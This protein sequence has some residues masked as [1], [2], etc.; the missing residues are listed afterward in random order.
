V[1]SERFSPFVVL[2]WHICLT[3]VGHN[4]NAFSTVSSA[5]GRSRYVVPFCIIPAFGQVSENS[6][7]PPASFFT[8]AS[9]QVCDVL[10]DDVSRSKF[11]N[12]TGDLA[13]QSA[14]GAISNSG[15]L[16][17]NAD[18]LAG[19]PA[20]DDIDGNSIGSKSFCGKLAHVSV[21]RDIGPVLGEDFARELFDFAEGDGFEAARSFKAKGKSSNAGKQVKDA[22]LAGHRFHPITPHTQGEPAHA[23]T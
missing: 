4:P 3:G 12:K 18:V 19:E 23:A 2:R 1:V 16:S 10:H 13:P 15:P 7:K 8:W 20:C 17:R 22:K 14:A 5:Q 21:A 9:K 6:A 11:A